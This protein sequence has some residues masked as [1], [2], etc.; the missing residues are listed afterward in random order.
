[1]EYA[2]DLGYKRGDMMDICV[3]DRGVGAYDNEIF[4]MQAVHQESDV[5]PENIDCIRAMMGFD[6]A[7]LSIGM[8]NRTLGIK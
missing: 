3:W 6:D 7:R 4:F 5:V 8:T 2:R 1:M